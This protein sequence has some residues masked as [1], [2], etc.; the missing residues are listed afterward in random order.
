MRLHVLK[1]SL[2][3]ALVALVIGV[4][5][6]L[7]RHLLE[8][9]LGVGFTEGFFCAIAGALGAAFSIVQRANMLTVAPESGPASYVVECL[10]RIFLGGFAGIVTYLA[11]I[12][13]VALGFLSKLSSSETDIRMATL[14]L[15]AAA[16]GLSERMLGSLVGAIEKKAGSAAK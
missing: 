2:T 5:G 4:G 12:S 13:N 1:T 8:N 10:G 3:A 14:L 6:W 11:C 15:V 9:V 7:N 16:S